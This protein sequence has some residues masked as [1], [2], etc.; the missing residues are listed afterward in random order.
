MSIPTILCLTQFSS[1]GEHL[2]YELKSVVHHRG[3]IEAGHYIAFAEG[4]YAA[5][6][7]MDNKVSARATLAEAKENRKEGFNPYM[8]FYQ[9]LDDALVRNLHPSAS[10]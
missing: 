7:V 1:R 10:T 2:R 8:L 9:R 3:N 6:S 5:W 4:P